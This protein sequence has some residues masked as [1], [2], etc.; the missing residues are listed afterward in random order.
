MSESSSVTVR[1]SLLLP[2]LD[3]G[4]EA[5]AERLRHTHETLL[6]LLASDGRSTLDRVDVGTM[7]NLPRWAQSS[8]TS[9]TGDQY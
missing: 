1:E 9:S 7:A 2:R 8:E 4:E 3:A 6:H 5:V